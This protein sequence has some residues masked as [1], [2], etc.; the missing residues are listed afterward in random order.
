MLSSSKQRERQETIYGRD[1]KDYIVSWGKDSTNKVV[2]GKNGAQ[3]QSS[4]LKNEKS[5]KNEKDLTKL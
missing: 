2:M 3:V 4:H 1:R 5:T